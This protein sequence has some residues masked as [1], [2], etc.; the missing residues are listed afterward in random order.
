MEREL[1]SGVM[2]TATKGVLGPVAIMAKELEA[3]LGEVMFAE[4]EYYRSNPCA[5]TSPIIL[6]M[7]NRKES[8]LCL[9]ATNTTPSIGGQHL[10]P[11]PISACFRVLG[12]IRFLA[13]QHA[14]RTSR[15]IRIWSLFAVSPELGQRF[16][17]VAEATSPLAGRNRDLPIRTSHGPG[18]YPTFGSSLSHVGSPTWLAPMRPKAIRFPCEQSPRYEMSTAGTPDFAERPAPPFGWHKSL[19]THSLNKENQNRGL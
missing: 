14:S 17:L 15:M 5:M 3:I 9:A 16:D 18:S 19:I 4:P 7:V 1:G 8:R 2:G 11:S 13:L 10:R 6:Y 12:P